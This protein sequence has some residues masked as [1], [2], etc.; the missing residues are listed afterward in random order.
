ML[1]LTA[2]LVVPGVQAAADTLT[3]GQLTDATR[4]LGSHL[5]FRILPIFPHGS[6]K[7][8]SDESH[9][10]G[11]GFESP[12]LHGVMCLGVLAHH[13]HIAVGD[14]RRLCRVAFRSFC[15]RLILAPAYAAVIR[16]MTTDQRAQIGRTQ[17][18]FRA[19]ILKMTRGTQ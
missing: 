6:P 16:H 3:L 1:V 5:V 17:M 13:P 7:F 2:T 10:R 15:L 11:Q 14:H 12:Q 8:R 4:R 19:Y 9:S 18:V